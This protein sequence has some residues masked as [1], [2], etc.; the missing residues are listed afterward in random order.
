M[1]SSCVA[2]G[3]AILFSSS[4][5]LMDRALIGISERDAGS[6]PLSC[7]P[8]I[9]NLVQYHELPGAWTKGFLAFLHRSVIR[10]LRSVIAQSPYDG[11]N[12]T[13]LILRCQSGSGTGNQFRSGYSGLQRLN[14]IS[15]FFKL[16]LSL[17]HL[18]FDL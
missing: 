12:D 13:V 3:A 5:V 10:Y 2:A 9:L 1:A 14:Q 18:L 4:T 16:F 17:E 15:V 7:L 6:F 11:A 8:P